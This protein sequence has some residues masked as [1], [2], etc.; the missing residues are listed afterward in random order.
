MMR[1]KNV[2]FNLKAQTTK[3]D[4]NHEEYSRPVMQRINVLF[5]FELYF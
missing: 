4:A 1:F 3:E 2:T 5:C